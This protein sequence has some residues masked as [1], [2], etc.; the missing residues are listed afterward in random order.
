ML[1]SNTASLYSE[2]YFQDNKNVY[3]PKINAEANR[4]DGFRVLSLGY[5]E[6]PEEYQLKETLTGN[7][8][9]GLDILLA[10]LEQAQN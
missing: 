3:A 2:M 1:D 9:A 6:G 8:A 4:P 7:S 10:D 5:A